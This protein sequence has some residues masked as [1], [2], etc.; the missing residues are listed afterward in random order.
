MGRPHA[1]VQVGGIDEAGKNRHS[2]R[3][4]KELVATT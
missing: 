2:S 3:A 4:M 1:N